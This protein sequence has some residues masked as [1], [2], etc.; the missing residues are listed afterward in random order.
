MKPTAYINSSM[1]LIW[2]MSFWLVDSAVLVP[3]A[4]AE[5]KPKNAQK[6]TRPLF[7]VS[8]V[9]NPPG[10]KWNRFEST[11]TL[12]QPVTIW[13]NRV[14]PDFRVIHYA[15]WQAMEPTDTWEGLLKKTCSMLVPQLS[16]AL[17][18]NV[19]SPKT[20]KIGK[21]P[22]CVLRIKTAD[23]AT[24]EHYVFIWATN[25]EK[26]KRI[27]QGHTVTVN[28]PPNYLAQGHEALDQF[29][30]SITAPEGMQ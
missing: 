6:Q 16:A 20:L 10:D 23:N 25:K 15:T 21:I 13:E 5:A 8:P 30:S 22:S 28:F 18:T 7:V 17:S 24:T 29:L 2:A 3:T 9:F 14:K 19:P 4:F 27:Y 1:V 26:S 12:G 11:E